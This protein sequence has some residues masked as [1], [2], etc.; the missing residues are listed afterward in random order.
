MKH[1]YSI[2][3][4]LRLISLLATPVFFQFFALG[5]IWHSIYWGVI[6]F[7]V[8]IWIA[9][10]M[11]SPLLGRVGCGWFCFMGTVTDFSGN[12][13]LYKT[14]WK[15][16]KIRIRLLM[17]ALF[18][19]SAFAFYFLN[20]ER[21]ITH[22]FAVIPTFLRL[23]FDM[24]YKIVWMTDILFAIS[25]ALFFNKRW[26]CKNLCIIGTLCSAGAKYSRLIAVVDTA[27]CTQCKKCDNECLVG[28]PI[29]DYI[30]KNNGLITNPECILCGKCVEI[31]K[32]DAVKLK[33]VWN[34]EKFR[35]Q[36]MGEKSTVS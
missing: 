3:F 6:T 14:K 16:P 4:L 7:A 12:H 22:D 1:I 20:K 11:L 23:D 5:F 33:F 25:I 31:C 26:V 35:Q 24:H 8:L 30:K 13:S 29:T 10:I 18:F 19:I 27:K 17:L 32:P 28:I 21:G 36:I 15:K 9:F 2:N 34:R